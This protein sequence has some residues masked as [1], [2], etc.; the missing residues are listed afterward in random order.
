MPVAGFTRAAPP[1]LLIAAHIFSPFLTLPIFL[2]LIVE[3]GFGPIWF[4]VVVVIILEMGLIG[5][6]VGDNVFV[7]KSIA[8]DAPMRGIFA[9]IP[10]FW[11]AMRVCLVILNLF[12]WI[13][14]YLP[15]R[16]FLAVG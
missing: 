9:A 4:G 8:E 16:M 2:P 15:N 10:P 11:L 5:P 1:A 13:A 6:P 12:P 7:V 3:L 14:T